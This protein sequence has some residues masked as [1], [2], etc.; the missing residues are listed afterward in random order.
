MASPSRVALVTGA[1][2]GIG[3]AIAQW[4]IERDWRVALLDVDRDTLTRTMAQWRD[5]SRVLSVHAD[6]SVPAD[7]AGAVAQLRERFGRIDALS[8]TPA[9]RCSSRSCRRASTNGGR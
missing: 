5:A 8:T 6:V 1:A 7:V 3:L 9:S 2:R 4:F